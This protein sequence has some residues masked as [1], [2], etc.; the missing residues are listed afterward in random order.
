MAPRKSVTGTTP[1]PSDLLEA[2][3]SD[4]SAPLMLKEKDLGHFEGVDARVG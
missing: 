3:A 2:L 4:A 1:F